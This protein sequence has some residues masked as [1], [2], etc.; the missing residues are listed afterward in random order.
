MGAWRIAGIGALLALVAACQSIPSPL[1]PRELSDA[2]D[3]A[4]VRLAPN[5]DLIVNLDGN[6]STGFRWYLNRAGEPQL[7]SLG[8]STY[9]QRS[10]EGRAAAGA[11][12]VTTFRFKADQKGSNQITF[13]YRRPWEV[14]LPPVRTVRFDVLVE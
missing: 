7:R 12:G 13:V 11:G 10:S 2:I 4:R 6:Q 9:T 1:L 5:Q 3:G 8:E 14:N